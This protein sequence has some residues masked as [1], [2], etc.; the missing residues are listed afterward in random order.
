MR[1]FQGLAFGAPRCSASYWT[2]ICLL[3]VF[4]PQSVLG[5]W[6]T[7]RDRPSVDR[8]GDPRAFTG[9]RSPPQTLQTPGSRGCAGETATRGE[10]V[11]DHL[12]R[13]SQPSRSS[14]SKS[15]S[16]TGRGRTAR[17]TRP[18][19]LLEILQ[20]SSAPQRERA[21]EVAVTRAFQD[22]TRE[23]VADGFAALA[24]PLGT[25]RPSSVPRRGGREIPGVR[26][27][28][29]RRWLDRHRYSSERK[30]CLRI[31]QEILLPRGRR[32]GDGSAH[33]T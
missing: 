12:L 26:S 30:M 24:W 20:A 8:H 16:S 22:R 13:T 21:V 1:L 10:R 5:S 18:D 19:R 29:A 7:S 2:A 4:G 27:D 25:E 3:L 17:A 28:R 9:Y 6:S 31:A 15:S 11:A 23:Q 33:I 32:G 14:G